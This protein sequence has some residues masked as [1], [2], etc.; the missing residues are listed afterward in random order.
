MNEEEFIPVPARDNY[1]QPQR[2]TNNFIVLLLI[3]ISFF[4][5]YLFFKVKNLEQK[6]ANPQAATQQQGQQPTPKQVTLDSVKKLFT[7][8][9]IYFGDANR[10]VLFVEFSDPSCPF[11]HVAGGSD[12]ELSKQVNP[13]FQYNTDGGTYNPPVA[14]MK[15]LVDE[16]KASFAM[17]YAN[18]HGNGQL[19]AQAMYCAN[20]KG[21][22][23]EVHDSLMSNKGY[24]LLNNK[25]QNDPKNIPTLVD[26][27]GSNIDSSFLTECLTSGK[28]AKKLNEDQQTAQS[29]GYQGTP[30]FL[31]NTTPF[32]GAQNF[33]SMESTVKSALG[34]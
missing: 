28:Y 6:V 5:G 32:A 31:I 1:P 14:A 26:F 3:V 23:W 17:L 4:A 2:S 30:H 29:M 20:E 13:S 24:D 9:N 18:G 22:F 11:C 21:K 12:P 15:K 25:V 27:L 10:K 7:K 19:G 34:G 16:G 33:K 8:G